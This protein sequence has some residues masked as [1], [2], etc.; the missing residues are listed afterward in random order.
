MNRNNVSHGFTRKIAS[1]IAAFA[2]TLLATGS[3][4]GDVNIASTP[5]FVQQPVSPALLL[6]VDD[7]GSMDSEILMRANDG[8]AWWHTG[9]RSFTGRNQT[10]A[11]QPGVI[12]FNIAG[13]ANATWK[14]FVYLFPNGT[15]LTS[16]R[17]AY[18]DSTNDHFAVPPIGP[19]AF[20]R[21]AA[22]NFGYF[23][24]AITYDPWLSLG[25]YSFTDS[26]PTAA[27]TDPT[28][29]SEVFDLTVS[30][31]RTGTNEV[32]RFF[33]G[34]VI[35]AGTRYR[36]WVTGSWTTAAVDIPIT[37]A[38]GSGRGVP[39]SYFPATF[40]LPV[41]TSLP[42]DFGYDPA[43]MEG[44]P[45]VVV[46]GE[47]PDGSP[48]VRYEIRPGNFVTPEAYGRAIQN[49]AN[50]F[51]YYR[52]RHIASRGAIGEAFAPLEGFRVGEYRISETPTVS[53]LDLS[54]SAERN[55]FFSNVYY[56]VN[57]GGTPNRR[58]VNHM[59]DQFRRTDSGAPIVESCQM[60]FGVLFTDGYASDSVSVGNVDGGMGPPFADSVSNTMADI[61]ARM[62]LTNLRPDLPS[63]N[64][65]IPSG[66][67]SA[68]P[69]P[70]L[71]CNTNL[72]ANLFAVTL[73]APGTIF[74]IDEDATNDPYNNPPTWPTSFPTR[75]PVHVDDLWHATLN[76]R[77]ELLDVE[78]PALLG[79]RFG[80]V[81]ASIGARIEASATSAATS[82]AVLQTDTLLY[83]AGFRSTDWSGQLDA[84]SVNAD[85]S[86]G[87]QAWDAEQKLAIRSPYTRN[88]FTRRAD[89]TAVEFDYDNLSSSQQDALDHGP[90]GTNDGL[91]LDRVNWLRGEESG[92]STFRDRSSTGVPRLLGDIVNS[93]PQFRA[94]V[95][96]VGANDGML[97]AF[98][99]T[100]GDELFAYVPSTLL[101]P[102]PGDDFSPLSRLPDPNYS[103]RYFVDGTVSVV[104][105]AFM[106]DDRTVLV[107]S[108]GAGGRAVFA[109]DV[110][111]PESFTSGELPRPRAR[112]PVLL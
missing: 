68:S 4:Q 12:N 5:L 53:M 62:Y 13:G 98:D 107:G 23:D 52:K 96:Y 61:A 50:W 109:L 18:S 111:N 100:T 42:P 110:S 78:V 30:R 17:R 92:P 87:T 81:L 25:G 82:S 32:F 21:S 47:A 29:G 105:M 9:D 85:G 20:V 95:L 64:V 112:L 40:Y 51:T 49:F 97:H 77:G 102:D 56:E 73:G 44:G 94:G 6:A 31:E 99:A 57:R 2:L 46:D 79:E 66:C 106:G 58:A 101:Q 41:G 60:N 39:V 70:S 80:E 16:G 59:Y 71:D 15:G 75:N 93:N 19:F 34:M 28:R 86:L 89:G 22:F 43:K 8:A 1:G 14:K 63:G 54:V 76:T 84:R 65:P 3:A 88:I 104:D 11:M 37:G 74:K 108:L 67:S 69:D 72:H 7:S 33:D 27:R 24:P 26:N 38:G 45:D 35:P 48:M 36:D 91:G 83:T 10:D 103:H 55:T 90:D